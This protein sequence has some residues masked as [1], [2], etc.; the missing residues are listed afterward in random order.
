MT[1]EELAQVEAEVNGF[2][3]QNTPVE[4]RIMTPTTPA[5]LARRRCLAKIR[6]A[7]RCA[8]SR[9]VNCPVRARAPTA[10]PIRWNCV[11][12]PMS[13]R[14]GDIGMFALTAETAS[15]AGIRRIEALTGQAAMEQLRRVD[16]E[17]SEIAGIIK[18]QAGDV[19]AKVR[20]LADE[21]KALANEVATLKDSL[22]WVAA[23]RTR[24]RIS[25]VSS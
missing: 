18:A 25:M 14:T 1:P 12:A 10:R 2:I 3:R 4:T 6:M 13:R 22:P 7:M 20:A 19:V 11:A 24:P 15:A 5:R 9:W 16:G 17:L 8:W 21:R 23:P